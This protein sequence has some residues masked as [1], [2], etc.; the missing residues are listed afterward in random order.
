MARLTRLGAAVLL[1]TDAILLIPGN[2]IGERLGV[3]VYQ[4]LG[5]EPPNVIVV[6][7]GS[8]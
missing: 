8:T 1:A 4:D 2:I 3:G 5:A 6:L 7:V